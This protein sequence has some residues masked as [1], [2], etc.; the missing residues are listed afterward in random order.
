[1][2][3]ALTATGNWLPSVAYRRTLVAHRKALS[4]PMIGA[5]MACDPTFRLGPS[6]AASLRERRACQYAAAM[7]RQ[8]GRLPV[9][10]S[11]FAAVFEAEAATVH[12]LTRASDG[13]PRI[14][15][16][17]VIPDRVMTFNP[18]AD[19]LC[20]PAPDE[21]PRCENTAAMDLGEPVDLS[22]RRARREAMSET[23]RQLILD[24][25]EAELFGKNKELTQ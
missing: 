1:M 14:Y 2:T 12:F 6:L 8:T 9:D 24:A 21:T 15:A 3:K 16:S 19:A 18:E 13:R 17:F 7:A 23:T 4:A 20:L 22:P 25:I 5:Q 11:A 10:Q